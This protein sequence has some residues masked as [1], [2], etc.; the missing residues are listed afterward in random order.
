M[1]ATKALFNGILF[2]SLLASGALALAADYVPWRLGDFGVYE[3]GNGTQIRSTVDTAAGNV[4][5]HT[6]FIGLG[7]LS[8][9]LNNM[10]ERV[11]I[12][13]PV[14]NTWQLLANFN[15]AVG[16][17]SRIDVDPCNR[18][19]VTVG[20][21]GETLN[22]PAGNFTN[23]V[24]LDFTPSCADAGVTSAWFARG[25]GP[26]QWAE[27][28][29]A[30]AVIY[31]LVSASIGGV[32]YP[33]VTPPPPPPPPQASIVTL[34]GEFPAPQITLDRA[35]TAAP[36]SVDVFFT[37]QN[38]TAAT[39]NYTFPSAQRFD[40][41]VIDVNGIVVS[42]W[43]RNRMFAQIIGNSSILPGQQQRFGGPVVLT[44]DNGQP[45]VP[46]GYTLKIELS[47]V[48]TANTAHIPGSAAP[49]VMAPLEVR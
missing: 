43:S 18:G 47:S 44:L 10:N 8:I 22:T 38:N 35:P 2:T 31:R 9:R 5:H 37:I 26:V 4:R 49:A 40:I 29:I 27:S 36:T 7:P 11:F 23:V 3:N 24:R 6:N 41:S 17:A 16:S 32:T 42:R 19:A 14:T 34:S 45:L 20:A 46:G 39:L 48:A 25:V 21:L 1:S 13:S 28:N 15:G 33:Q 12:N 30:G